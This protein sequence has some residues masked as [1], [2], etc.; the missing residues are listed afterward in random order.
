MIPFGGEDPTEFLR[1]IDFW[2]YMHH[3]DLK[4]AFGRAAMESLAAG[5]VAIMPPYMKELFGDA[6]LYAEPHQVRALVDEYGA[7][8]EK[9]LAQSRR[10]QE[11][12]HKFSPR[13]HI[14]RLAELGATP[15]DLQTTDLVT[16]TSDD[17]R[18][19]PGSAGR[20]L[21]V[22]VSPQSDETV[23]ALSGSHDT[24][25]LTWVS[26]ADDTR[27]A[28]APG[29]SLF[30]SSARRMNMADE[31]WNAYFTA[32]LGDLMDGH[33]PDRVIF[34]GP[35]PPQAII[36]SLAGVP[37]EKMWIQQPIQDP[38]AGE[39]A[40]KSALNFHSVV[41]PGM[42]QQQLQRLLQNGSL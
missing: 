6:A 15:A 13:M 22:T 34:S 35:I 41:D 1:R 17:N 21:V 29:I 26:V 32:R 2:V 18:T 25:D 39:Q 23:R 33:R 30:I 36:D 28:P 27:A 8:R 20:T 40:I 42:S 16:H 12:T 9:F 31:D 4:E 19:S 10:A 24:T 7:D 38:E 37:V 5:C 3:P 11:F 14:D